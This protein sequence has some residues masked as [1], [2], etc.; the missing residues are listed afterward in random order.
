MSATVGETKKRELVG[1]DNFVR[2][3][4]L[5]DKF[6]IDKFAFL[7]FYCADAINTSRRF[8]WGLGMHQV[9]KSDLT[10]GNKHYASTVIQSKE[11][12]FIFSSPYKNTEE[13]RTESAPPNPDYDQDSAHTFI[14]SKFF[15]FNFLIIIFI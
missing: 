11:L 14:M 10:T 9:G 7:E 3:N 1:F 4:P 15:L 2:N 5:S 12:Q 13:F 8:T 6:N